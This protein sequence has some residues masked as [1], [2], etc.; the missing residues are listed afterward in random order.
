MAKQKIVYR[1]RAQRKRRRRRPKTTIPVL[2]MAGMMP[3]LGNT[4]NDVKSMGFSQGLKSSV[5]Y[6]IPFDPATGKWTAAHLGGGLYPMI[7]GMAAHKIATALGINRI[8][9]TARVPLLRA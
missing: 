3:Y 7:A 9:A 5:K 6:V 4:V 8:L 2:M 1:N